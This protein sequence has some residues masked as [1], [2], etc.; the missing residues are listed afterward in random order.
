MNPILKQYLALE[1]K[2]VSREELAALKTAAFDAHNWFVFNRIIKVLNQHPNQESFEI[3]EVSQTGMNAPAEIRIVKKSGKGAMLVTDGDKVAWIMPRQQRKD[4]TFTPGVSKALKESKRT[5]ASFEET[6]KTASGNKKAAYLVKYDT[7]VRETPKAVLVRSFNGAEDWLPKVAIHPAPGFSA[8]SDRM[9]VEQWALRDKDIQYSTKKDYWIEKSKPKASQAEPV[10]APTKSTRKKAKVKAESCRTAGSKMSK[11]N[12]NE[13]SKAASELGSETCKPDEVIENAAHRIERINEKAKEIRRKN[14]SWQAAQKRATAILYNKSRASMNALLNG[15]EQLP[16]NFSDG[17]ETGMN[18][19]VTPSDIYQHIT[20]TIIKLIESGKELPWHKPWGS[21]EKYGIPATN[22][23][24]KKAYR[25]INAVML[26]QVYPMER[27]EDWNIPY[28][29]TFKQIEKLGGKLLEGSKGYRVVYFTTLF[30][31][32]NQNEKLDF[33]TYKK[34]KFIKWAN[35]NKAKIKVMDVLSAEELAQQSRIP[36]LKYYNV[37]N[38]DDIDGIDWGLSAVEPKTEGEKIE[39]AEE[40]IDAW[41]DKPPIRHAGN[42]AFY[43]PSADSITMPPKKAFESP[44]MYYGTLFHEMIHS[45]GHSKRLNRGNDTRKRDGSKKSRL[46]YAFEELIAEMGA[47]FLNAESG[48]LYFTINNNAAYLKGWRQALIDNMEKDSRFFF[49][50]S[51]K[52]QA[53]ADYILQRDAEGVPLYLREQIKRLEKIDTELKKEKPKT[54]EQLKLVLN[55]VKGMNGPLETLDKIN[56]AVTTGQQVIEKAQATGKRIMSI[57]DMFKQK[58]EIMPLQ[59]PWNELMQNVPPN[60]RVMVYGQ[61][62]NGKTSFSLQLAKYLTQHGRV[63]YNFADQGISATTQQLLTDTGLRD[64]KNIYISDG[65]TLPEL[66]E[67]IK[68]AK[69]QFVFVDLMNNYEVDPRTFENFMKVQ[70]PNTGFILV[71]EATK[72][73]DFRG[74]GTWLNIV[75][76]KIFCK[77]FVAHNSGRLGYGEFVIWP[78]RVAKLKAEKEGNTTARQAEPVEAQALN[79]PANSGKKYKRNRRRY[80]EQGA[81]ADIARITGLSKKQVKASHTKDKYVFEVVN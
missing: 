3:L 14:E 28:F 24:S 8:K 16:H 38:A 9:L 44:Q 54:A 51:S 31:Y 30:K 64:A 40:I 25:G 57:N 4:G 75:D 27:G 78:E 7:I 50:A 60:L 23:E 32:E 12:A 65:R 74:E 6:G 49:R 55:G 61:G 10:E 29:L 1:G 72:G 39:T 80:S 17:W 22:F 77:D 59:A 47:S 18:K 62:K 69:P 56:Q 45:T 52:A 53:A 46:S 43:R 21:V 81:W 41:E 33:G 36:I 13:R 63:L 19:A 73:E 42:R 37:F 5:L 11:G 67:A 20:D 79:A 26:N 2:T 34:S 76:A 71:M 58:F 70:H 68:A 66:D 48:I 35:Q 15:L